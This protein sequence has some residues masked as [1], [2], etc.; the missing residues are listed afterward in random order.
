MDYLKK[1][2]SINIDDIPDPAEDFC[3]KADDCLKARKKEKAIHYLK[4]VIELEE[5]FLWKFSI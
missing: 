5:G 1:I 3:E 4:K 2:L